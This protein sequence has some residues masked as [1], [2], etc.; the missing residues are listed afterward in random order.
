MGKLF[1][2]VSGVLEMRKICKLLV[3]DRDA[4]VRRILLELPIV[5]GWVPKFLVLDGKLYQNTG[6]GLTAY[7]YHEV[8]DSVEIS[9]ETGMREYTRLEFVQIEP[10]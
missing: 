2:S 1:N 4:T 10:S 3:S 9:T 5:K 6:G 8:T 7:F